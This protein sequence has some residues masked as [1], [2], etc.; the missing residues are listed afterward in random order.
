MALP[1][2]AW[3]ALPDHVHVP[4]IVLAVRDRCGAAEGAGARLVPRRRAAPALQ[5]GEPRG[6]R[7]GPMI[8]AIP[9]I[10]T[11]EHVARHILNWLHFSVHLPWAWSIVALTVIV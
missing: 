9:V 5:P 2:H 4:P 10:G 3:R 8:A 1:D 6:V 7:S 11:L